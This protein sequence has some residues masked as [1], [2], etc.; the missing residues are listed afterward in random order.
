MLGGDGDRL[1]E[2]EAPRVGGEIRE[3]GDV[4]L[5][6]REHDGDTR[7]PQEVGHRL[8]QGRHPCP[9]VDEEDCD[10]G[11]VRRE[12]RLARHDLG[13]ILLGVRHEPA[14]VGQH[15]RVAVEAAIPLE[16]VARDAR[17]VVHDCLT[18]PEQAVEQARLA[19]VRAA[20][21]RDPGDAAAGSR[22]GHR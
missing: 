6:D 16:T 13:E 5:V 19:H 2:S 14:G 21:E 8:V 7:A 3:L 22:F 17:A 12:E 18:P 20:D 9:P 15:D 4:E 1:A 10:V 11:L